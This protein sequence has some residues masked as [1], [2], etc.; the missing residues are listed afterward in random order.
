MAA[1]DG[2]GPVTELPEPKLSPQS[3]KQL[4][5]LLLLDGV[6]MLACEARVD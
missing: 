2:S 1:D 4:L 5:L 6:N 3:E